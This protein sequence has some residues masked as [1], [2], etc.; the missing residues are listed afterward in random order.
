VLSE[1]TIPCRGVAQKGDQGRAQANHDKIESSE[2]VLHTFRS[3]RVVSTRGQ[4]GFC[5]DAVSRTTGLGSPFTPFQPASAN[6]HLAS[7]ISPR[8]TPHWGRPLG[9]SQTSGF[10]NHHPGVRPGGGS[11]DSPSEF[12]LLVSLL[13]HGDPCRRQA[14]ASVDVVCPYQR[15]QPSGVG[16][17]PRCVVTE[18][19]VGLCRL[20]RLAAP[21]AFAQGHVEIR[22][23]QISLMPRA[24]GAKGGCLLR[25]GLV[26]LPAR[27]REGCEV[28]ECTPDPEA[29]HHAP[30]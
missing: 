25:V 21:W 13:Q 16:R 26:V 17:W 2:L 6:T 27:L 1:A 24:R 22:S 9:A 23:D 5:R 18:C 12:R 30:S 8:G 14:T 29:P 3:P 19:G 7:T 20:A 10:T 28:C 4:Q 15:R 11:I